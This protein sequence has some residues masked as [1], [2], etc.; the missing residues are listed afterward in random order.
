MS[1]QRMGYM[2]TCMVT[3]NNL[4]SRIMFSN[5]M[6]SR[7]SIMHRQGSWRSREMNEHEYENDLNSNPDKHR[8]TRICRGT[9]TLQRRSWTMQREIKHRSRP[10][11]PLR[12]F[13]TS[14]CQSR[15]LNEVKHHRK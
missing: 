10:D 13:T 2:Y 11:S 7:L 1:I 9:N 5:A 8:I 4:V 3:A 15:E 12:P 14:G 6:I